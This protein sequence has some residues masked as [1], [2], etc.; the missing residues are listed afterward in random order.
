M[1]TPRSPRGRKA[2][3]DLAE[4]RV[5]RALQ[6]IGYTVID[7][8][9]TEPGLDLVAWETPSARPWCI[10]V[11]ARGELYDLGPEDK[12]SIFGRDQWC[13][14]RGWRYALIFIRNDEPL[15]GLVNRIDGLVT[16]ERRK[17][18]SLMVYEQARMA[19][20]ERADPLPWEFSGAPSALASPRADSLPDFH[21][22]FH[23]G[24]GVCECELGE[25]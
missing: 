2:K 15:V 22:H 9:M 16:S 17:G 21:G 4:A 25:E 11:K 14:R 8:R 3:G 24:G 23:G 18:L 20:P 1:T 7:G 5:K 6:D 12:R 13:V 19:L 10:E